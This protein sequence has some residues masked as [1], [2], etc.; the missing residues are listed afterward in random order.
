M[1]PFLVP[2]ELGLSGSVPVPISREREALSSL[3]AQP[4]RSKAR[5]ERKSL[6]GRSAWSQA[7][8]GCGCAPDPRTRTI[9]H[10]M[11]GYDLTRGRIRNDSQLGCERKTQHPCGVDGN[12]R[13]FVRKSEALSRFRHVYSTGPGQV[14]MPSSWG[15]P[16]LLAPG[17]PCK[18]AKNLGSWK[19]G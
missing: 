11:E 6:P 8:W 5:F 14:G 16:W 10:I 15:H 3:F 2:T 18:E 13:K 9:F 7:P 19:V 4:A 17:G 12:I 1:A